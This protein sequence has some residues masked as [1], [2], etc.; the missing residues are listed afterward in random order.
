MPHSQ[1]APRR[2]AALLAGIC[3][4]LSACTDTAPTPPTTPTHHAHG[5][6]VLRSKDLSPE[7]LRELAQ[8]RAR[9]AAF[10]DSSTAARAGWNKRLTECFSDSVLGGMGFHYGNPSLIDGTPDAMQPEI[11]LFEPLKNG[12]VRF[13]AVEYAVPFG[14]CTAPE[15]PKLFGQYFHRNE[16]FGLWILHVWQF[17]D[18]PSGIFTDWNPRVSCANATS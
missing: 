4:S 3:V 12:Q 7:I 10:H 5:G 15:P 1:L 13:V 9:T 16:D 6:A 17:D 11:L 18:N 14:A 2:W 8:L